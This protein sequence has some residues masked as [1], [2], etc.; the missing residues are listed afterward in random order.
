MTSSSVKVGLVLLAHLSLA[1]HAWNWN[2][3]WNRNGSVLACIGAVPCGNG[4]VCNR[5]SS[6]VRRALDSIVRIHVA[7]SSGHN[8]THCVDDSLI[9]IAIDRALVNIY[10]LIITLI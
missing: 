10:I 9:L 6:L 3:N 8:S 7:F 4:S 1:L 5:H 2:W